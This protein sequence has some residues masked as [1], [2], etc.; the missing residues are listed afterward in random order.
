MKRRARGAVDAV[1][2]KTGLLNG[3]TGLSGYA[4][5]ADGDEAVFSVLL[6]GYTCSDYDAMQA[7]D[8][9]ASALAG[10]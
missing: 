2:A 6:N 7:L 5:L 4:R 9:F 10:A 3:V 8:D 1:R